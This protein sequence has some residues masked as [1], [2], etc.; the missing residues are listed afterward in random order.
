[1]K[2][3]DRVW[4]KAIYE[5]RDISGIGT[6]RSIEQH[7]EGA[8]YSVM[9]DKPFGDFNGCFVEPYKEGEIIRPLTK[10]DHILK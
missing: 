3:G 4:A 5:G 8:A 1:M 9:F 6:I 7:V 10:L 2:V